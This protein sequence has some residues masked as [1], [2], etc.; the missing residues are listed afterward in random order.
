MY[1]LY[2]A[3]LAVA[4][5]LA[6]P[7][8]LIQGLRHGKYRRS[9][10]ARWGRLPSE[11]RSEGGAIWLHAVSVGEVLACR[12][13]VAVLRRHLPGRKLFVSTT[14]ETG[15]QAARQRLAADGF[16]Y[17]PFDF[18]F[19][20]RR[21]LRN[22]RPS[23]VVIAE[24]ELWPNL[25][26]EARASGAMVAVVNARISDRSLPRYRAFRFFFRR[27]LGCADVLLAQSPEDAH[28]LREIGAL[29]ER[30]RVSGIL[31]YDLCE[32]AP[33]PR[34]LARE[35][36]RWI[37]PGVLLAGST[38]AGEEEHV[39]EGFA[40]LRLRRHALRLILVPRRPE[41]FDQVA[42]MIQARGLPLARRSELDQNH[43][44]IGADVLL[45]DTVG[46]LGALYR[47][48]SVAFV[49]GSLVPHGGQN[50]LEAAVFARP[51][52]IGPYMSN[53]R[54][55][56]ASL[57]SAGAL[58]QVSSPSELA[59]ALE[60]LFAD[61]VLAREMGERALTVLDRS[62]GATERTAEALA[63]LL[64]APAAAP[65]ATP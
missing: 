47:Y 5:A 12:R 26:R 40:R 63:A 64:E 58:V 41:R 39:L 36:E 65:R 17:C 28:R 49:G 29:P 53:F 57:L 3:A 50:P 7:Y 60:K 22:L 54:D 33:L 16:F 15:F 59:G 43:P 35:L 4:A 48:A 61:P 1:F 23:L 31:K 18:A 56:T 34:W 10:R 19:A 30:V 45:V 62:R 46:E 32:P 13:L 6:F 42:A 55:I 25:F 8:F 2:S 11:A 38:A 14:T 37:A 9:F 52:V 21:V 27:V 51:V 20:V 44:E 24:T